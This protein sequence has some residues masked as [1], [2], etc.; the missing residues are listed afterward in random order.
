MANF[1][2]PAAHE[3]AVVDS[4]YIWLKVRYFGGNNTKAKH[5]TIPTMLDTGAP[6]SVISLQFVRE[7]FSNSNLTMENLHNRLPKN[8]FSRYSHAPGGHGTV[9]TK[10]AMVYLII[11]MGEIKSKIAARCMFQ[12]ADLEHFEFVILGWDVAKTFR[13][14]IDLSTDRVIEVHSGEDVGFTV[15]DPLAP[16]PVVAARRKKLAKDWHEEE[17]RGNRKL[18]NLSLIAGEDYHASYPKTKAAILGDVA[19]STDTA[20]IDTG[21]ATSLLSWEMLKAAYPDRR[22]NYDTLPVGMPPWQPA[23]FEYRAATVG[24]IMRLREAAI[25]GVHAFDTTQV[26]PPKTLMSIYAPENTSSDH[27]VI[28]INILRRLKIKF[29]YKRDGTFY[30]LNSAGKEWDVVWVNYGNDGGTFEPA[31]EGHILHKARRAPK[32]SPVPRPVDKEPRSDKDYDIVAAAPPQEEKGKKKAQPPKLPVVQAPPKRSIMPRG[33]RTKKAGGAAVA[34]KKKRK[35]RHYNS[36]STYIYKVLKQVHPDTGIS[37]KGMAIMNSFID[38]MC[39]KISSQAAKMANYNKRKTMVSRDIQSAVRIVM[40][41]EL[42]KHAI[43]EGT[44]AVL[45]Y[46]KTQDTGGAPPPRTAPPHKGGKAVKSTGKAAKAG[47]VF[48]VGR[49]TRRM[50]DGLYTD[51]ISA[52]APVYLAAVLE[53]LCAEVSELAGN[54]ARD[55]KKTRITPRCI[56]LAIRMD[57]ELHRLLDGG[58]HHTIIGRSG[59]TVPHIHPTLLPK[60]TK[61]EQ[62]RVDAA[63][64][65]RNTNALV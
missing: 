20:F 4:E 37:S 43:S 27:M 40:R 12:V 16:I 33:V 60:V 34:E 65:E 3:E 54:A 19:I 28:G 11:G 63:I 5:V 30:A 61:K 53:Y 6:M 56:L 14:E 57:E 62:A 59:D 23:A 1:G 25:D 46:N 32:S 13:L 45:N 10:V 18:G 58:G 7:I 38:D 17:R 36:F 31:G 55:M 42:A 52:S 48:S 15:V 35:K 51:R 29:G 49:V 22:L 64:L 9:G 44:K 24:G 2:Y 21:A 8:V 41:G 50:R 47:I 39:D 26:A